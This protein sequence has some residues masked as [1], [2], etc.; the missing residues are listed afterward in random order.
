VWTTGC[1][2]LTQPAQVAVKALARGGWEESAVP[3]HRAVVTGRSRCIAVHISRGSRRTF[4][5]S[6]TTS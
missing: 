1:L 5:S 2:D 6:A 3:A 4:G